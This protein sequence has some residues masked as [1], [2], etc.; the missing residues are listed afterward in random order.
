MQVYLSIF[1]SQVEIYFLLSFWYFLG[2]GLT[3]SWKLIMYTIMYT[4]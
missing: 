3:L 4:M 1:P 2:Q